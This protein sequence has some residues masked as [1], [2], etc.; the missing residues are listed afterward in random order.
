MEMVQAKVIALLAA[1]CICLTAGA[2]SYDWKKIPADASR[3][4]VSIPGTENISEA[5][6][7]IRN[8]VYT[9]P[10][11]RRYRGTVAWV[12]QILMEAQIE[13]APVKELVGRTDHEMLREKPECELSNLIVDCVMARTAEATGRHVDVGLCNFGGIR[14]DF[15]KGDILMDDVM[16]MLP[17]KNKLCYV[18]LKGKDLRALYEQ[19]ARDG[20]QVVGGVQLV[21][22]DHKL[23]SATIGGKPLDDRKTYGLATIDFLLTGGDG[24]SAAR[25]ALDLVETDIMIRDAV[26]PYLQDLTAEGKLISYHTD[27]RVQIL[28]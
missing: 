22:K 12:A 21:V 25:N 11:G 1:A 6:G 19:L 7:T 27:G 4:G 2:Q 28:P 10:N 20:M 14:V 5:L 17:F 23:V 15:P 26:L 13:M 9:A 16:S 8:G 24:I 3:T 18:E